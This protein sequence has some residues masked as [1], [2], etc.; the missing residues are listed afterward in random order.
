MAIRRSVLIS[1]PRPDP[2]RSGAPRPGCRGGS[3]RRYVAPWCRYRTDRRVQPLRRGTSERFAAPDVLGGLYIDREANAVERGLEDRLEIAR[4]AVDRG[5]GDD[6]V[7]YLFEREV[8]ADFVTVLCGDKEWP[9]GGEHPG[10]TL[11]EDGAAPIQVREQLG[12]DVVLGGCEGEEPAQP[13][14]A[15]RSEGFPE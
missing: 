10:A 7:E 8:V 14:D 6:H 13:A 12:S 5:D 3:G 1:Q 15:G 11:A 4:S 9:G 2:S